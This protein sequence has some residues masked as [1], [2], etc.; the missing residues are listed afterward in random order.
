MGWSDEVHDARTKAAIGL[1][2][3]E[4]RVRRKG[5][6]VPVLHRDDAGALVAMAAVV[7]GL[8]AWQ[9]FGARLCQAVASQPLFQQLR[10]LVLGHGP[11]SRKPAVGTAGKAGAA[12]SGSGGAKV[13]ARKA[14]TTPSQA[15]AAA[16]EARLA[17]AAPELPAQVRVRS[18]FSQD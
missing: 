18:G 12:A 3:A 6:P 14:A 7:G 9:H 2:T 13:T 5:Y 10:S 16:A 4:R 1:A 8:A 15:A 17:T 11:S